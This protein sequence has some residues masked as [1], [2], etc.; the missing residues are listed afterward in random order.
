MEKSVASDPFIED[1]NAW[2]MLARLETPSQLI[3]PAAIGV[4][5]RVLAVGNGVPEYHHRRGGM[6]AGHLYS[7]QEIPMIGGFCGRHVE[8]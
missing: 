3:G 8:S 5:G 1:A 2:P 4:G 7:V 6:R